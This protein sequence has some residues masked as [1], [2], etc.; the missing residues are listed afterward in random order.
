MSNLHGQSIS[1]HQSSKTAIEKA[2][3]GAAGEH[4]PPQALFGALPFI[5]SSEFPELKYLRLVKITA[6]LEHETIT[7][8][9]RGQSEAAPYSHT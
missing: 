8:N 9:G 3:V 7:V 2:A 5:A 1:K 4:R 6:L